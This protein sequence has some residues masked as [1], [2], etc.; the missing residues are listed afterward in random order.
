MRRGTRREDAE[1]L[2]HD[3]FIRMQQYCDKGGE[4]HQPE[5]FLVRTATRLAINAHRDARA[6]SY[7]EQRVEELTRL[8][9]TLPTPDEELAAEQ[10][11]LRMRAALDRV[12]SRTRQ[13]FFM[14]LFDGLSQAQIAEKFGISVSAVEKHVAT[15]LAVLAEASLQK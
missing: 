6:D 10:C 14:H 9:D 7:T 2:I 4:V 12:S 8:M 5:G 1:D 11:L 3:A 15:A 13:V